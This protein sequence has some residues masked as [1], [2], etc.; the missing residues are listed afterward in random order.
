MSDTRF[1]LLRAYVASLFDKFELRVAS[2]DASFRRYFRIITKNATYIAMD[3]PPHKEPLDDF[4]RVAQLFKK[5]SINTP[6]I[7]FS[8]IKQGFLI[9]EDFGNTTLLQTPQLEYYKRAIDELIA[10]QSITDATLPTYTPELLQ[11]EIE[12]CHQ[13]Y[14]SQF[15]YADIFTYLLQNISKHKQVVVHR[16]FHSRNIM[17]HNNTLGII[18]FQ[19]SVIGSYVYDLASL[20]RDAYIELS[21]D[22][23]LL[24]QKYFFEKS[25][26]TDFKQFIIDFDMISTQR[27]IKILGIFKRLSVRDGKNA[28]LKNIPLVQKYLLHIAQ[29]YPQL[30]KLEKLCKQ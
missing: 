16:D 28:Y 3:A 22:D 10:L 1:E 5:H 12:L 24:L 30:Q 25:K 13:W 21:D 2:D 15:V 18:D 9:L 8:N 29:K 11:Y 4:I 17:I 19:D 27:H 7:F 20:L 26:L 23:V 6:E 14:D